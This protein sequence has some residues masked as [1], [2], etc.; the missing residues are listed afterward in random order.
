MSNPNPHPANLL[1]L[2][3]LDLATPTPAPI[4]DVH[5]HLSGVN[6]VRCYQEIAAAYGITLTFSMSPLDQ[7]EAIRDIMGDAVE[8]IGFPAWSEPDRV[9]A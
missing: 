1:E 5:T 7:V 8:L 2:D 6:A 4:I 3:Y 9:K